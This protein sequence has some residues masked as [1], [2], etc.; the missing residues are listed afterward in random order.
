MKLL[1]DQEAWKLNVKMLFGAECPSLAHPTILPLENPTEPTPAVV[2]HQ[3]E[4][5]PPN[6]RCGLPI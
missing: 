6:C 1:M 5:A 3:H 2:S 4:E